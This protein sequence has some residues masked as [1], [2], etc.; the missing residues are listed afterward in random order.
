MNIQLGTNVFYEQNIK[1]NSNAAVAFFR[2]YFFFHAIFFQMLIQRN[3]IMDRKPHMHTLSHTYK[4]QVSVCSLARACTQRH[5]KKS[6]NKYCSR[7]H[8]IEILSVVKL[9]QR[10]FFLLSFCFLLTP[11]CFICI[12]ILSE[13]VYVWCGVVRFSVCSTANIVRQKVT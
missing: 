5:K 9:F 4:Q 12:F 1:N 8:T 3:N 11:A 7:V 6:K 2:Q 13:C 10:F